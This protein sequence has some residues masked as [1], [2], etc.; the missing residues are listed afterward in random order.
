MLLSPLN[1]SK[2]HQA[3]VEDQKQY[4]KEQLDLRYYWDC[5]LAI[6]A[7]AQAKAGSRYI[8]TV[9]PTLRCNKDKYAKLYKQLEAKY[10]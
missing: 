6:E 9:I 2:I 4:S 1:Y 7:E 5:H 10:L 3:S 8:A